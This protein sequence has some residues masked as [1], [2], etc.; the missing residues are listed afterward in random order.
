MSSKSWPSRISKF[1]LKTFFSYQNIK[2]FSFSFLSLIF[3]WHFSTLWTF[4]NLAGQFFDNVFVKSCV[5]LAQ[6]QKNLAQKLFWILKIK[7]FRNDNFHASQVVKENYAVC[8]LTLLQYYIYMLSTSVKKQ[9]WMGYL[10]KKNSS[11]ILKLYWWQQQGADISVQNFVHNNYSHW[12]KKLFSFIHGE[13]SWDIR[14]RNITV[15]LYL[16]ARWSYIS[17]THAFP[18]WV[19]RVRGNKLR[20]FVARHVIFL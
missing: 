5:S 2:E 9:K 14:S 6:S 12:S 19:S 7:V 15:M 11:D 16:G 20:P 8:T 1:D 17:A 4:G 3:W 18:A 10:W 13:N